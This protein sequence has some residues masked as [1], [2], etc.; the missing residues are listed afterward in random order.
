MATIRIYDKLGD[1]KNRN[2]LSHSSRVKKAE[3]K[4]Y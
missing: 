4:D 2:L 1:L 3:I